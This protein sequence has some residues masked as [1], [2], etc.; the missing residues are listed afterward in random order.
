MC[1]NI[2]QK[3]KQKQKI[4]DYI[5]IYG[6]IGT[7][8]LVYQLPVHESINR[9]ISVYSVYSIILYKIV[10]GHRCITILFINRRVMN[11]EPLTS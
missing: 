4:Y 11:L 10:I 5:W 6:Y 9:F 7:S 8:L 1:F 3:Q 2:K